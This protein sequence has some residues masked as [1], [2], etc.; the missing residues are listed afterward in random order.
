M[1]SFVAKKVRLERGKK[2]KKKEA[3]I[4]SAFRMR[5]GRT[6]IFLGLFGISGILNRVEATDLSAYRPT[7]ALGQTWVVSVRQYDQ[8]ATAP[9]LQ[10]PMLWRYTVE[11]EEEFNGQEAWVLVVSAYPAE[12]LK[13]AVYVRKSD[14]QI[15]R[16]EKYNGPIDRP[17]ILDVFP[18][19]GNAPVLSDGFLPP[20]ALPCC[21]QAEAEREYEYIP[22]IDEVRGSSVK[23]SQ[24]VAVE[25][26]QL[27]VD[28]GRGADQTTQYWQNGQPWWTRA[29]QAGQYV[30]ETVAMVSRSLGMMASGSAALSAL[31]GAWDRYSND[32]EYWLG[33]YSFQKI[34]RYSFSVGAAG[35]VTLETANTSGDTYMYL[36]SETESKQIAIDDDSGAGT[37]SRISVWLRPGSYT[38][39]IRSYNNNQPAYCDLYKNGT[40][41]ITQGRYSGNKVYMG[42]L[43]AET[44]F[45]TTDLSS[46]SDTYCLLQDDNMELGV[47]RSM[48]TNDLG[49]KIAEPLIGSNPIIYQWVTCKF[50]R[51]AST[52]TVN[53]V[54]YEC[55]S[56]WRSGG[57]PSQ[58]YSG[59][60]TCKLRIGGPK[61][62]KVSIYSP[63]SVSSKTVV[64]DGK[65]TNI[66]LNVF[67]RTATI[68][69]NPW[70]G[71]LTTNSVNIRWRT[72]KK[73]EPKV[74]YWKGGEE[75][76]AIC[77]TSGT[78]ILK[79]DHYDYS[80]DLT[81]LT[82]GSQ[83]GYMIPDT[84]EAP[85]GSFTTAPAIT[86]DFQF[87]A[88]G[89]VQGQTTIH[90]QVT[91]GIFRN[92]YQG[93]VLHSGDMVSSGN[94]EQPWDEF[95]QSTL[96]NGVSLFS[97]CP[98]FPAVGNNDGKDSV[99]ATFSLPTLNKPYYS[100][101]YANTHFIILCSTGFSTYNFED[102]QVQW[103]I[104]DLNSTTASQSQHIVMVLHIP[105]YTYSENGYSSNTNEQKVINSLLGVKNLSDIPANTNLFK[106]LR[107]VLSGHNHFYQRM[108]KNN[109]RMVIDGVTK[110]ATISY[111]V[112]GGG[113][114]DSEA[115]PSGIASNG[116]GIRIEAANKCSHYVIFAVKGKK[117]TATTIRSTSDLTPI[118]D[119]ID[120]F[121]MLDP[122]AQ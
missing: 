60:P 114:A 56:R 72:D 23:V 77:W 118:N 53:P 38:A 43:R 99:L 95:F 108:T 39:F 87:A 85:R 116:D 66:E 45:R 11:E 24:R 9:T 75:M 32:S 110:V 1:R 2:D 36:W 112:I 86:S 4:Y 93:F 111:M 76:T 82:E 44:R 5:L 19:Q 10:E 115:I 18:S 8:Q 81:N 47:W 73:A 101:N 113:G 78:A 92:N 17:T 22:A 16:V 83:Y 46:G 68:T 33:N 96:W 29:E 71:N 104:E 64:I 117:I 26:N 7:W 55:Y 119:V 122:Y 102:P 34:M 28:W 52:S 49:Y 121:E 59:Y 15:L 100:F 67:K 20:L 105:P 61:G 107:V 79:D 35:V 84:I 58:R 37:C 62:F 103:L 88:Y 13:A 65:N 27:R 31:A 106:K 14:L 41:V 98:F 63:S 109:Y 48:G 69:R 21:A 90:E 94:D 6:L 80:V 12:T 74:R 70:L 91:R 54:N 30:A 40:R 89:D 3:V 42:A 120:S 50:V 97:C 51:E 25:G 57:M